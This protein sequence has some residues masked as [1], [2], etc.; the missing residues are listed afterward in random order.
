MWNRA[1]RRSALLTV[2]PVA[3][4]RRM[5][6]GTEA[7]VPAHSQTPFKSKGRRFGNGCQIDDCDAITGIGYGNQN[8]VHAVSNE[9]IVVR[10][11]G[12][13]KRDPIAKV[14]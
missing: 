10:R 3:T 7:T 13:G 12:D 8:V 11:E 1:N 5:V 2:R 14:A 6:V 4:G 9:R